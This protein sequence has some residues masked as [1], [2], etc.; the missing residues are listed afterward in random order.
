MITNNQLLHSITSSCIALAQP[1]MPDHIDA[2]SL[3]Y[4]Q[5][6]HDRKS[7]RLRRNHQ[8]TAADS[9]QGTPGQCMGYCRHGADSE[10]TPPKD[11]IE[12][13]LTA[14]NCVAQAKWRQKMI[15]IIE[16]HINASV[17]CCHEI[18][19]LPGGNDHI[20]IQKKQNVSP[21]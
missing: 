16:G 19:Q 15:K 21:A 9:L 1:V 10:I 7:Q 8:F 3:L 2:T 5:L 11:G 14:G 20:A 12:V 18:R 6:P 13:Q 17:N 4:T